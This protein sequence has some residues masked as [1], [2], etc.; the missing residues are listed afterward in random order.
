MQTFLPYA[1]FARSARTLD[2]A[3]LGKQRLEVIEILCVTTETL[4]D[5]L[6]PAAHRMASL[7]LPGGWRYTRHRNH[8]ACRMWRDYPEALTAY[9]QAIVNEWRARG[10]RHNL[11]QPLTRLTLPL[12]LPPWLGDERVHLSHRANLVRKNPDYYGPQFP[13]VQPEEEYYWPCP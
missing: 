1:D 11:G 3:R 12:V 8:P 9:F 7:A 2:R 4:P 5:W 6:S 10:Y 13:G